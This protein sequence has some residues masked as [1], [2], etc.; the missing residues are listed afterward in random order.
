CFYVDFGFFV[1]REQ[2]IAAERARAQRGFRDSVRGGKQEDWRR[3]DGLTRP[4][5]SPRTRRGRGG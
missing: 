1:E 2:P 3:R 4:G 5:P